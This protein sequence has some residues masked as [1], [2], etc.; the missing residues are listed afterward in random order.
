M[1]AFDYED[2]RLNPHLHFWQAPTTPVLPEGFSGSLDQRSS[3]GLH[4][5]AFVLTQGVLYRASECKQHLVASQVNVRWKLFE[6]FYE[7]RGE[8]MSFGFK[9]LGADG[10]EDFYCRS[11]EEL[12][13][14]FNSLSAVCLMNDIKNDFNLGQVIGQGAYATVRIAFAK[15][16]SSTFAVKIIKKKAIELNAREYRGIASEIEIMRSLTHPSL[17]KLHRVYDS[18]DRV[19]L[20]MDYVPHLSLAEKVLKFAPFSE[21]QTA[22]FARNLLE[23]VQYVHS[24]R[25]VHRDIK[26]ANILMMSGHPNDLTFKIADFGLAAR[27]SDSSMYMVC[28]SPGFIAPEVL[29]HQPYDNKADIFSVGV[30]LHVM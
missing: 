19:C 17:V 4:T 21:E 23:A 28:G 11:A 10:S 6:P 22:I 9:L 30:V 13:L 20:V 29:R 27:D 2:R 26:P 14:W 15:H 5:S 3:D 8:E 12:E 25:V 18:E 24:E 1:S 16:D 7:E